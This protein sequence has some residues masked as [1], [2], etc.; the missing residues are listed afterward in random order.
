MT[1]FL[2]LIALTGALLCAAG[3]TTLADPLGRRLPMLSYPGLRAAPRPH[4][5]PGPPAPRVRISAAAR[6][7][8]LASGW[9][10]ISAPPPF[11]SAGTALLM[12]DGTVLIHDNNSNWYR[13]TPDKTGNY[14]NGTWSRSAPLPAGYAPLYFASAVLPDG[15]LIIN[16]GEY[17]GGVETLTN[18]GA[19]YNPMLDTWAPVA[20]PPGWSNIGDAPSAVLPNGT[21]MLGTCCGAQQALYNAATNRWTFTGSGKADSNNE[22]GWTLLPNSELLVTDVDDAPNSQVYTPANG[23]WTMAGT[24]SVNLTAGDEIGPQILRQNGQVF[25][26]GAGGRTALYNPS[27]HTWAAGP[28]FPVIGGRQLDVADGPAALLVN[29]DVIVA[30]SP[31]TYE[32]PSYFLDFSANGQSITLLPGPPNAPN[33]SS[34]NYRL[35]LLPTGQVLETDF[36]SDVEIYTP[37]AAA[38]TA[39]APVI[40]SVPTALTH[41]ATYS[42]YGLRFSGVSQSNAYGDDAQAATNYPL[43]AIIN[44]ASA[45][46]FFART[47]AFSSMAVASPAV[48]RTAFDVPATIER[49][50]SKLIVIANGIQS[51][52]VAV[53]LK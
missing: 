50:P 39:A 8:A 44:D 12:T 43:V 11:F 49:G 48:V 26:M 9:Q 40:T 2:R 19:I 35:L 20:A 36:S 4:L 32:Q 6:T 22:E 28:N 30:A 46:V 18:Q 34:Y 3:S 33:N 16:G 31:G 10:Q 42:A 23:R 27:T 38:N 53:T 51:K 24:L 15:R 7:R 41:G 14:V 45:H 47:H 1:A 21:Y 17:N 5:P 13:L 52:P 25:V 37:K 29:G